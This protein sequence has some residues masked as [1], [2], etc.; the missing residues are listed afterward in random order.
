[1]VF[2]AACGMRTAVE[3]HNH[4]NILLTWLASVTPVFRAELCTVLNRGPIE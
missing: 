3:A 1:M 2:A 4:Q